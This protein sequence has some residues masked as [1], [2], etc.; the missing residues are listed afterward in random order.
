MNYQEWLLHAYYRWRRFIPG[1]VLY[2]A[3]YYRVLQLLD[4]VPASRA[5]VIDARLRHVLQTAVRHVPFYRRQVKL[6]DGE[7][8]NEPVAELLARF[9]YTDKKRVMECQHDFL[10]ERLN[11]RLLHYTTSSG[12]T[13]QGIGVWRSKRLADIE[14]AFF[15]HEWSRYG[16]SFD[17][18]RYLRIGVDARALP[19]QPPTRIYGNRLMLSPYHLT[20]QHRQ[21]IV[22]A[23]NRFKPE[24]M[25]AYP[26]C[27][28]AL[29]DLV[30]PGE[31]DFEFKALLLASEPAWPHQ[32]ASMERL[33]DCPISISYGLTERTNLAFSDY[34]DRTRSVYRF[35][36]L[37]AYN[38]NR[39]VGGQSEIVGTSLWNDV[40]PLI[41]YC[42][43]D[44]GLIAPDGAC[45]EIE[46]REQEFLVDRSGKLV[47][48]LTIQI[49]DETW[50]FAS[51][52]QIWQ[53]RPGA[54][55]LALVPRYGTITAEQKQ[56]VL[57][58]MVPYWGSLFDISV[59]Q[60]DRI[61]RT[62]SGK[63]R[64]VISELLP[65]GL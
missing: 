39:S 65:T 27:V 57:D 61:E 64:F 2:H 48:A 5:D 34:R 52:Y 38:E 53:K 20:A 43:A 23:L 55:T 28:A 7:L 12:S 60:V 16:F 4:A 30:R 41:R 11:P 31:L 6:T 15:A 21:A 63:H 58:T 32:L 29:A 1:R 13:G 22:D 37:Y 24:Y 46:G 9:P 17:K 19:H 47:A 62:T 42:T 33:F 8:A 45:A 49:D 44:Y 18:S 50:E 3:D 26:S 35:K 25:H 54:I 40:M 14:K 51:N 59:E 36:S 10:D 56:S